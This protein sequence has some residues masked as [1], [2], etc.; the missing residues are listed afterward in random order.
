MRDVAATAKLAKNSRTKIPD[1]SADMAALIADY[2]ASNL[3]TFHD[4]FYSQEQHPARTLV[5]NL[6]P[7]AAGY[8]AC[9]R[10]HGS[11]AA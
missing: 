3:A 5:R 9:L 11:G 10:A 1:A 2:E 4:W 7:F 8:F 6:R